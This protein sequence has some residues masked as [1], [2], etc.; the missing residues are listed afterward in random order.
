MSASTDG[1]C[2]GFDPLIGSGK[3]ASGGLVV[4]IAL[5]RR[6]LTRR[7][8]R[9]GLLPLASSVDSGDKTA[10]LVATIKSSGWM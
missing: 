5:T 7:F 4:R 3:P 10:G 6:W 2:V 1:S 9:S 8:P